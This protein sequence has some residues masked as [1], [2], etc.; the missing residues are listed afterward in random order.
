NSGD[1]SGTRIKLQGISPAGQPSRKRLEGYDFSSWLVICTEVLQ[2]LRKGPKKRLLP[3]QRKLST[4]GSMHKIDEL[5]A[6]CSCADEVF[7]WTYCFLRCM[8][9][10]LADTVAKVQNWSMIIFSP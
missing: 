6:R 5:S 3:R 1:E 9:P 10:P 8:S 7:E 2:R 4:H